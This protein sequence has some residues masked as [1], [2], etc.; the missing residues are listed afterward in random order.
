MVRG[1]ENP[2]RTAD[3]ACGNEGGRK[4]AG[5]RTRRH[6]G[7]LQEA[8]RKHAAA[9]PVCLNAV[10][11]SPS[12]LGEPIARGW[13]SSR[14]V[15]AFEDAVIFV[16]EMERCLDRLGSL[17]R[18]LL[19]RVVLQEYTQ[20]E[21]AALLG[22]SVRALSYKLPQAVDRLAEMLLEAGLFVIPH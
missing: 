11:R 17:D 8:Y 1:A 19:S 15:R 20:P 22:M 6:P 7:L 9:L 13:C 4:G 16:L 3:R 18:Q 12:I 2:R 14:P 21:A 5:G 10:G